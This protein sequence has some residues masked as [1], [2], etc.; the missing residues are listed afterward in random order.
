METMNFRNRL[1][2]WSTVDNTAGHVRGQLA[3]WRWANDRNGT[4]L[5]HRDAQAWQL[6]NNDTRDTSQNAVRMKPYKWSLTDDVIDVITREQV[7]VPFAGR[8]YSILLRVDSVTIVSSIRGRKCALW[9]FTRE[10]PRTVWFLWFFKLEST[11]GP[12]DTGHT[13]KQRGTTLNAPKE[14]RYHE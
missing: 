2:A 9:R 8:R 13:N 4:P 5:P 1:A 12:S 10:S 3:H 14:K 11:K 6:E 7:V